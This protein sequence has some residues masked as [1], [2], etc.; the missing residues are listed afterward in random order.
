MSSHNLSAANGILFNPEVGVTYKYEI[1]EIKEIEQAIGSDENKVQLTISSKIGL[2]YKILEK[3]N[4]N[5]K[6]LVQ[7][8]S[9]VI[10]S[11]SGEE[12]DLASQQKSIEAFNGAI[13]NFNLSADGRVE[14]IKGFNEFREKFIAVNAANVKQGNAFGSMSDSSFKEDYFKD[15]FEKISTTLPEKTVFVNSSWLRKDSLEIG[16]AQSQNVQ[17]TLDSISTGIAFIKTISAVE[18]TIDA[19]N[20]SVKMKGTENGI[21]EIEA[22]TGMLITSSQKSV[23]TGALKIGEVDVNMNI[24]RR[25]IITGKKI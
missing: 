19:L 3:V 8:E 11:H 18:Q 17:C 1:N 23:I 9:C 14:N 2:I 13:F 25:N 22:E 12:R 16:E 7:F 10:D 15:I 4:N 24:N 20:H 6:V 21:I 5:Y